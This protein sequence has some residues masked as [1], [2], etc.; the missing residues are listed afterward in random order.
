MQ[1]GERACEQ[2][3][4]CTLTLSTPHEKMRHL[5]KTLDDFNK[6]KHK[7][8]RTEQVHAL[9]RL[10]ADYAWYNHN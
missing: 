3:K 6:Y 2:S 1:R 8:K 9:C 5:H 7:R 10:H 4:L